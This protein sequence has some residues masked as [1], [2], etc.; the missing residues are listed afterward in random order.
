MVN[1]TNLLI[2]WI[3]LSTI[4]LSLGQLGNYSFWTV[5]QLK[6]MA[7]GIEL[8]RGLTISGVIQ[9]L[10]FAILTAPLI[11]AVRLNFNRW[12]LVNV[13]SMTLALILPSILELIGNPANTFSM[14]YNARRDGHILSWILTYVS[15]AIFIA[16]SKEQMII[17][18]TI[19]ALA[20]ILH[21]VNTIIL[22]F[23]VGFATDPTFFKNYNQPRV[24]TPLSELYTPIFIVFI[25]LMITVSLN[26]VVFSKA[27]DN[28]ARKNSR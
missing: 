14:F 10:P 1:K 12:I 25:I 23:I 3:V 20:G 15:Q 8:I 24:V 18:G 13:V 11:H 17:L 19:N 9:S 6:G 28:N 22:S 5:F 4:G 7:R 2:A 27:I 16:R 26:A 21:M